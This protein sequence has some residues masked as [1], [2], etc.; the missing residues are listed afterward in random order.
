MRSSPSA[1]GRCKTVKG[2]RQGSVADDEAIVV[3]FRPD[4]FRT[5]CYCRGSFADYLRDSHF[6][7]FTRDFV[8]NGKRFCRCATQLLISADS[9]SLAANSAVKQITLS[10]KAKNAGAGAAIK[11]KS[12]R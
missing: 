8:N 4:E 9:H 7:D 3:T 12:C 5:P 1:K 6:V 10:V 11:R 2:K